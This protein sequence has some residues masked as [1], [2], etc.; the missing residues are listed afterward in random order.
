M[1]H[2]LL[3]G[4]RLRFDLDMMDDESIPGAIARGV[5]SHVLV[6]TRPVLEA[7]GVE[8]KHAGYSQ[9][10]T[11]DE[12]ERLAYVVRCSPS[13]MSANAGERFVPRE[14]TRVSDVRFGRH[15]VPRAYLEL[16]QRRISPLS[17]EE[18][19]HHRLAW[20]NLLLPY[21]PESLEQLTS[22]CALCNAKLGW[23]YAKGIGFCE[24]CGREVARSA[25]PPLEDELADDYRLFARLSSPDPRGVTKAW[26]RCRPC[27]NPSLPTRSSAS[28]SSLAVSSRTSR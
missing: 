22:A 28:R 19:D 5:H 27:F 23:H 6:R 21:C 1:Q 3:S 13:R 10:A 9:L 2:D 7:A 15:L 24:H 17:L 20:M 16:N 18:R 4:R 26:R 14:A 8:L 12:L 11:P 25:E